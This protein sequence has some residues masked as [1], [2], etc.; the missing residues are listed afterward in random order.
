MSVVEPGVGTWSRAERVRLTIE[1]PAVIGASSLQL[2]QLRHVTTVR[3]VVR[4][5]SAAGATDAR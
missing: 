5:T 3:P 2:A 4:S 1:R